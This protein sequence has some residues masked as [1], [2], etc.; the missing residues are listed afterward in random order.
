[1]LAAAV[2]GHDD[3]VADAQEAAV[4][5]KAPARQLPALHQSE[6]GA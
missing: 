3:I 1:M 5:A 2:T 4:P 6:A